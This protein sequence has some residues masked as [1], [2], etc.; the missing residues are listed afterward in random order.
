MQPLCRS[1]R[2]ALAAACCA[3]GL[4]PVATTGEEPANLADR[5]DK[6][7]EQLGNDDYF[8][9]ERAQQSL[10]RIGFEAFDALEAAENHDD[11]EVASRAKY[12]VSHMQIEWTVDSDPPEVKRLLQN[13]GLKDEAVHLALLGQL[14]D[15][16]DDKGLPVLCRLVRFDKSVLLSK[17]A[18]LAIV[19]QKGVSA[20]RWPAREQ[21]IADNLGHSPRPGAEWLRAH[22]IGHKD[23]VAGV[24]LWG[25]LAEAEQFSLAG[26][27]QQTQTQ[28]VCALWRQQVAALRKLDRRDEAV[29]AMMRIVD[30]E[31]GSNETLVELVNWLVGQEAWTVV[32]EVARRFADRIERE[33]I[34]L[35]TLAQAQQAQGREPAAQQMADKALGLNEGNTFDQLRRHLEAAQELRRRGMLKWCQQEYRHVIS[36]GTPGDF[37]TL[38]AQTRLGEQLH[39]QGDDLM[40]AKY[41]DDAV[42]AREAK[43]KNKDSDAQDLAGRVGPMETMRARAHFFHACHFEKEGDRERQLAEL[44]AGL[45]QDPAEVDVLIALYRFPNLEAELK[46][47]VRQLVRET[48]DEFRRQIRETPDDHTPYNQIA[49]LIANTEGDRDEARRDSER[50]LELL[51]NQ[52][53]DKEIRMAEAG[54]LDTLARCHYAQGDLEGAARLQSKAVELDPYSGQMN[55]QLALFKEA[56]AGARKKSS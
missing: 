31:E 17:L 50:S 48:A 42:R 44:K 53:E 28:I 15:L 9:R 23:P 11:V 1:L 49:W 52:A 43:E 36:T 7:I 19:E 39:D 10:A 13:Y 55:K 46:G 54:F 37:L 45:E 16:P 40:A 8:I 56:L 32:D 25:K 21:A 24:E 51:R 41:W 33:P 27:P 22:V 3:A 38:Y 14:I 26:Q 18:A 47:K 20:G 5:V 12:L 35:Y 34:L 29:G 6:L 4:L 30:L 2:R